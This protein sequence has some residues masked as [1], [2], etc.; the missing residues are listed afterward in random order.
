MWIGVKDGRYFIRHVCQDLDELKTYGWTNHNG[1][2]YG[3]QVLVDQDMTLATSFFKSKG[4]DS[5][6]G[7]DWVVRT[8]VQNEKYTSLTFIVSRCFGLKCLKLIF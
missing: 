7:G 6:Y 5:G 3:H 1:R 4:D 2:D 8:E